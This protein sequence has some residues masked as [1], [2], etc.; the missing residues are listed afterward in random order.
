M[1]DKGL[2]KGIVHTFESNKNVGKFYSFREMF[3]EYLNKLGV[4]FTDPC[5]P[6]A[7]TTG[8]GSNL[9]GN[10]IANQAT[11]QPSSN[12][13]I[14]DNGIIGGKLGIGTLTPTTLL[15]VKGNTDNYSFK[16]EDNGLPSILRRTPA[17]LFAGYHLGN[18]FFNGTTD[19]AS[20]VRTG[21]MIESLTD[22]GW[23]PSSSPGTL[24]L[25]TTPVGSVFPQSRLT[26]LSGGEVGIGTETPTTI[27]EVVS[28]IHASKP[29]PVMTLAQKTAITGMTVGSHVYQTD[30]VEG[31]YVYKSTGWQFA[32]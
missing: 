23:T 8:G 5:C 27:F 3:R 26:I 21:A 7:S 32:Y 2:Q 17:V 28:T 9:T 6:D 12:F 15:D 1:K 31:V 30:G 4:P 10:Y 20:T 22:G 18:I 29:Y 19:A 13:N 11:Q 14:S 25:S 16:V 24:N